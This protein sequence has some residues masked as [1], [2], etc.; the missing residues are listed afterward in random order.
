[1]IAMV[2]ATVFIDLGSQMTMDQMS[3]SST[4]ISSTGFENACVTCSLYGWLYDSKKKKKKGARLQANTLTEV[5]INKY[6][7]KQK[8]CMRLYGGGYNVNDKSDIRNESN[9]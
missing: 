3:T 7:S 1:M 2:A 4:Y 9:K 6:K 8:P 5:I